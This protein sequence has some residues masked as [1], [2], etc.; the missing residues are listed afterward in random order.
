MEHCARRAT[1]R[2]WYLANGI[3]VHSI[4]QNGAKIDLTLPRCA[5]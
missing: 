4:P 5:A 2:K 3:V 1:L